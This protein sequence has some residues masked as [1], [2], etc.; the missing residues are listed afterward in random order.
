MVAAAP[1]WGWIK[2]LQS[3]Q[4]SDTHSPDDQTIISVMRVCDDT[5]WSTRLSGDC[6]ALRAYGF[7]YA[8]PESLIGDRV[9]ILVSFMHTPRAPGELPRLPGPPMR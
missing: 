6:S 4:I 2:C 7:N 9:I 1:R 3:R 5:R 8:I